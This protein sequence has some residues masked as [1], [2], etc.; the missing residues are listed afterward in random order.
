MS[1]SAVKTQSDSKGD[2]FVAAPSPAITWRPA[3]ASLLWVNTCTNSSIMP[4]RNRQLLLLAPSCCNRRSNGGARLGCSLLRQYVTANAANSVTYD[5]EGMSKMRRFTSRTKSAGDSTCM[6][7]VF[8]V[9]RT[10]C[11]SRAHTSAC[12]AHRSSNS[13][14]RASAMP[15]GITSIKLSSA[16]QFDNLFSYN[17]HTPRPQC[18]RSRAGCAHWQSRRLSTPAH[19]W[20]STTVLLASWDYLMIKQPCKRKRVTRDNIVLL[21]RHAQRIKLCKHL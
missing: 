8:T 11:E 15:R 6:I 12:R 2:R 10:V 17:E 19:Y 3:A 16:M 7:V 18:S 13:T 1:Y 4:T 21:D 14:R 20:N 5:F 9:S